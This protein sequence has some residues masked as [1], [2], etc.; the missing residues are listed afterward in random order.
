MVNQERWA[1]VCMQAK[2][3]NSTISA[4]M[5]RAIDAALK[6]AQKKTD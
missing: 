2:R 5:N 1:Q 6:K 4:W 3:S